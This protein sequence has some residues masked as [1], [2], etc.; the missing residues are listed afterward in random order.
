MRIKSIKDSIWCFDYLDHC[1]NFEKQE[2]KQI[3]LKLKQKI[4]I[5]VTANNNER[6]LLSFYY[7]LSKIPFLFK[8]ST[9]TLFQLML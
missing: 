9:L 6:H 7:V 1:A 3:W 5:T 8:I 2:D 4:V